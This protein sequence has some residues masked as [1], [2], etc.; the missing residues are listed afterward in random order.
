MIEAVVKDG[1]MP[2]SHGDERAGDWK[3]PT[4]LAA[5]E[6]DDLLAWLKS[7][8]PVGDPKQGPGPTEVPR[9]WVIGD[10]DVV[11]Y[12][13]GLAL[14]A[15]G[16]LQ[17][18]RLFVATDQSED[19]WV[20]AIEMRPADRDTV[21]HALVWV[22]PPGAPMPVPDTIP[23]GLQLLGAYGLNGEV[24]E[25]ADDEGRRLPAGS[26]LVVDLYARPMG[27]AATA[28]L[29]IAMNFADE[30]PAHEVR[31]LVIDEDG[32]VLRHAA[33]VLAVR[34]YMHG[35]GAMRVEARTPGE[36]RG[37]EQVLLDISRYDYRW[38]IAYE[39][40]QPMAVPAGTQFL[41]RARGEREPVRKASSAG[42]GPEQAAVIAV[43]EL[44]EI[45]KD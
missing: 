19:R 24:R 44:C 12:S 21:Q 38:Q 33:R 22:L 23:T 28:S 3:S 34:P 9:R 31:T 36:D 30:R 41:V 32:L 35:E 18:A 27:K 11:L 4:A 2:P 26:M 29:R 10:P 14:P 43:I 20:N 6:R 37:A 5:R 42:P 45:D 7:E 25:H 1:L 15:E 8:R 16:S 40:N 17:Y 39:P 13:G